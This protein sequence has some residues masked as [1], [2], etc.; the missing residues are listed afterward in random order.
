MTKLLLSIALIAAGFIYDL[1]LHAQNAV[2]SHG[3]V[4][5]VYHRFGEDDIPSTNIRIEQ[6]EEQLLLLKNG[7]FHFISLPDLVAKLKS[8]AAIPDKSIIFT[9][10]D[11]YASIASEG[12]PRLKAAGIPLTIFVST[13]PVDTGAERYLSWDQLRQLKK[14][15]VHIAH[16]TQ[17]HLHMVDND[18]EKVRSDIERA[19]KRFK[20]ELGT[21][22]KILAYPYGE[23]SVALKQNIKTMGFDAAFAQY[24]SVIHSKSD[25]YALPRFPVNERYGAIDRFKLISSAKAIV[26]HDVSPQAILL[27]ADT[28]PP[29]YGFTV[30][31]EYLNLKSLACY[32]SH[33]GK[34]A[35]IHRIG[36]KRIE[37]RFDKAFLPGRNR[38]N[39]TMPAGGGRWYWLGK[40]FYLQGGKLD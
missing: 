34:A 31:R 25:H 1:P 9:A 23:Y 16:H 12:W 20:Q 36:D 8:G 32:P 30:D 40:F 28:N 5:L 11:A 27:T 38:I 29:V 10:D 14:E 2:E 6:F 22:P 35:D 39:C 19:N 26:T 15:G 33:L 4:V 3:A 17:S 24:S 7:G 37:I 21:I 13:G 18:F